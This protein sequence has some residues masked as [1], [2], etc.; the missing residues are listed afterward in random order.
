MSDCGPQFVSAFT[1]ELARLLQYDIAL[2]SA[3]HPQIDREMDCYNQELETYL[4]IFCERQPQKW[5]EL[6][7]MAEFAHNTAIH[8]VTSKSPFSIIMEYES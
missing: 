5:L 7:L 6:L 8:S 1:R 3:Y 2:S 4:C